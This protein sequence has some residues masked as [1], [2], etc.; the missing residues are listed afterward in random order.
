ML[1]R[2]FNAIDT[3]FSDAKLTI[4]LPLEGTSNVSRKLLR[5]LSS[6]E[7]LAKLLDLSMRTS[8]TV[9]IHFKPMSYLND[10]Q[11]HR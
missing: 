2:N 5:T 7:D 10:Y 9:S 6:H 1:E 8:R 4:G 11:S 3:S